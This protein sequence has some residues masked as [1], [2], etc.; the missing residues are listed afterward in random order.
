MK[1]IHWAATAALTL[2]LS[3]CGGGDP[4]PTP[5][6]IDD[7]SPH[8]YTL[9]YLQAHP[10]VAVQPEHLLIVPIDS[11]S[12]GGGQETVKLWVREPM[13]LS[14]QIAPGQ[15]ALASV[16][17]VDSSGAQALK[18]VPGQNVSVANLG[19]GLAT[20]VFTPM[21]AADASA[22]TI[23][24]KLADTPGQALQRGKLSAP[25]SATPLGVSSVEDC[26][27]CS[28]DNSDL[29][30][31]SLKGSTLRG[32]TFDG[33][34]MSNTDF[35]D[36]DCNSCQLINLV[37]LGNTTFD[38]SRLENGVIRGKSG[39]AMMGVKFTGVNFDNA[40]LSG[41]CQHC[42]FGPS[43][44]KGSYT[45]MRGADLTNA[46]L[47][48]WNDG[49]NTM[50]QHVD[51]T[52]ARISA[53]TFSTQLSFEPTNAMFIGATFDDIKPNNLFAGT[54]FEGF[55][56]SGVSFAGVDLSRTDLSVDNQVVL[57]AKTK[58]SQAILNNENSG[59]N[60]SGQ[61]VLF[62]APFTAWAGTVADQGSGKDLRFVNLSNID[63]S[64]AD[65]TRINL[66]GAILLGTNLSF[67]DLYGARLVGAQL[68]VAPGTGTQAAA[69]L[70]HAYMPLVNLSD[71]DLRS[72]NL[73]SAHI[74]GDGTRFN[75]A[76]LDSADF[77]NTLLMGAG[78]TQAS[79]NDTNFSGASLV[80]A[81]FEAAT[82]TN[83]KFNRAY[84]QGANF[85][86]ASVIGVSLDDAEVATHTGTW[87][88]K[89]FD[90]TTPTWE[91]DATV[92]GAIATST[93]V[94]CPNG[95]RGPCNAAS[96]TPTIVPPYPVQPACI[97][98]WE[99]K[100]LNCTTGWVPPAP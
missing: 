23:Y 3:A 97:P 60:L 98:L 45:T 64:K 93:N 88:I 18:Q 96:L 29:S 15:S 68:G 4:A 47:L 39:P 72:V 2:L 86:S 85:S 59:V 19:S 5:L 87:Q 81:K 63:L 14:L 83:A 31:V 61:N 27:N 70:S 10:D 43:T 13:T 71:A 99:F 32:S 84:L 89:E 11:R 12:P 22:H 49:K 54:W 62:P 80:N 76:R 55:D 46:A 67:T 66:S 26:I 74:Y 28:F 92:L 8:A 78:L 6:P 1:P 79:A 91:Y 53:R 48:M 58:L 44:T 82:L 7:A 52:G 77:T 36:V 16:A 90:G 56:L 25:A 75:R 40:T 100:Y 50:L 9:A 57:S 38:H 24:L 95:A 34:K 37:V 17:I 73:Q 30:N 35:S 65:L 42:D 94:T 20:I 21:P 51:F 33:V 41:G 69:S